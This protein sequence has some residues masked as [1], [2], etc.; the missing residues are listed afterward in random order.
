MTASERQQAWEAL[1]YDTTAS[2]YHGKRAACYALQGRDDYAFDAGQAA[3]HH[4]RLALD[5]Y[6]RLR[7]DDRGQELAEARRLLQQERAYIDGMHKAERE[8][9][10]ERDAEITALRARVADL[11]TSLT[12][13]QRRYLDLMAE[14]EARA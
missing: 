13:V 14:R 11:T 9:L 1:T 2:D 5:A 3:F 7:A 12:T 8:V 10:A 6:D 4:A